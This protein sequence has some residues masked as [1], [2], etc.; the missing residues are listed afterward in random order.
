M[1]IAPIV[2]EYLVTAIDEL[3]R[4]GGGLIVTGEPGWGRTTLLR[5][6]A[7]R[8]EGR[9]AVHIVDDADLLDAASWERLTRAASGDVG[10]LAAGLPGLQSPAAGLPGL[11]GLPSPAAGLPGIRGLSSPAAG[12]PGI[13]G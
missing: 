7:A 11:P 12:P 1:V 6:A 9:I 13:R 2:H 3:L 8:A 10:V 4:R 5:W